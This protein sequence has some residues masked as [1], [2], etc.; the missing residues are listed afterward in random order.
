MDEQHKGPYRVFIDFTLQRFYLGN[1]TGGCHP[2]ESEG[3]E[4]GSVTVGG[5]LG[6]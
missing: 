5:E 3:P 1:E 4:L 6:R 2:E